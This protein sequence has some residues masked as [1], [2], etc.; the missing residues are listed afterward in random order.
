MNLKVINTPVAIHHLAKYLLSLFVGA[1]LMVA[2]G[3]RSPKKENNTFN[4]N[5][6]V[7]YNAAYDK[8]L[9]SIF[10]LSEKGKW[11]EAEAEISLLLQQHE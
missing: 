9:E 4:L 3:C 5:D 7:K 10:N 1:A 2:G 6:R 8:E 11:E